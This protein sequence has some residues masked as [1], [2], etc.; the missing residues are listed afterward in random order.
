M[1][2]EDKGQSKIKKEKEKYPE[3]ALD[4]KESDHKLNRKNDA[5]LSDD[6]SS[7]NSEG[8]SLEEEDMSWISWFC[9]LKGNEFF[10]EVDEDYI[11]DDF[12][13][14]GLPSMIPNYEHALDMILDQDSGESLSEEQQVVVESSAET[15]Y[16]L[17]HA[18][19]ILTNRGLTSMLEKFNKG[20]FGQCPRVLCKGQAVLPV[21]QVD[22][23][24]INTVKLFCAKCQEIYYP[25]LRRHA[26]ID[27]AYFGTT[28]PHLLLQMYPDVCPPRS[29]IA[30][31]PKIYGFK[32]HKSAWQIN[33]QTL[34]ES[35][36]K[37]SGEHKFNNT[38]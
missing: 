18:R 6:S 32:I 12:N 24:Q 15:L 3:M 29:T 10:C 14:T 27:G 17:I 22:V 35:K 2:R 28:F 38:K 19:F 37:Q 33:Q 11:Q 26:N 34:Q 30:Y 31:V 20:D 21:G 8:F 36:K 23:P 16:G 5:Y 13:L 1:R 4:D 25:K 9:S 7:T